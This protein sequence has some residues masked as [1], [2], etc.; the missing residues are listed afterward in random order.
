MVETE[1]GLLIPVLR[2]A[3]RRSPAELSAERARLVE[4][5]HAGRL[6]ADG[7]SGATFSLSNVGHGTID[8]F[9]AIINP[10]QVAILAAGSILRRPVVDGDELKIRPTVTFTLGADHRAVDGR[11]AAAFLEQLKQALEA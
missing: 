9:T 7:L 10:P 8:Q 1:R 5:A 3:G 2:D 6:A 11:Q 4:Q